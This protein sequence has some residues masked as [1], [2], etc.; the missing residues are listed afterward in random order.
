M[1]LMQKGHKV[2]ILYT[3]RSECGPQISSSMLAHVIEILVHPLTCQVWSNSRENWLPAVVRDTEHS[4]CIHI[5]PDT[6]RESKGRSLNTPCMKRAS[7]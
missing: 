2:C 6:L 1:I 4:A 5:A 3:T 7:H